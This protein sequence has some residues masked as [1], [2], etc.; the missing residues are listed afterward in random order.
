[1]L[2]KTNQTGRK[3]RYYRYEKIKMWSRKI[4]VYSVYLTCSSLYL[5]TYD[6][7]STSSFKNEERET[8]ILNNYPNN[9]IYRW[10]GN[11]HI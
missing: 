5:L 3:V 8:P 2:N 6:L 10:G 7:H 9:I 4:T 11:T 1:M